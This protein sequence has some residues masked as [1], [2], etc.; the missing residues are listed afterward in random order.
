[1]TMPIR[2]FTKTRYKWSNTEGATE[3]VSLITFKLRVKQ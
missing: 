3:K 1:M 2:T